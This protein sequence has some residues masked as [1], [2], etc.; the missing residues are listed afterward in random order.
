MVEKLSVSLSVDDVRWARARAKRLG[1]SVSGVLS[2]ALKMAR[3]Q[4][5]REAY[6]KQHAAGL[7]NARTLAE[8]EGE[9]LA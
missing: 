1:E 2:Q 8:I 6:L 9:W 7:P 3:Q 4:E 5:A